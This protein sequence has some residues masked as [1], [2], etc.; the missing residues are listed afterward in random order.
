MSTLEILSIIA[1]LAGVACFAAVFTILYFSHARSTNAQIEAGKRDIE[2]IDEAIKARNPKVKKRKKIFSAIKTTLFVLFLAIVIPIFIFSL[3]TRIADG[4]PV[5]GKSFLVVASGSM[6]EL[7]EKNHY[8]AELEGLEKPNR[9]QQYDII[10][11]DK[12][13]SPADLKR[14]DVVAY[15][16]DRGYTIIH[17]I[18][19]I[20]GHG[21]DLK[22]T[23]CGDANETEDSYHATF[24]DVIG[25]YRGTRV[26]GVGIVIMFL[27]SYSGIITV[28]ALLY[29]LIMA[30]AVSRKI[31][32]CED[33][34]RKKLLEAIEGGE[35]AAKE[36]RAEF[37][38]TI[39]YRGYAYRFDEK[40][41]IDKTEIPEGQEPE[42]NTMVKVFESG[43]ESRSHAIFIETKKP[44]DEE[45][46]RPRGK[47]AAKDKPKEQEES[48]ARSALDEKE[49]LKEEG[50]KA[51]PAE[52]SV[53][54]EEANPHQSPVGDSFP[55]EEGE[56]LDLHQSPVGDSFPLGEGKPERPKRKLRIK[57]K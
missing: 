2:L 8:Y 35:D 32:K 26:K 10:I 22:L 27:Q 3:V 1:T 23:T 7:N 6:S 41:F 12:V 56:A 48:S 11:L 30:D 24:E 47:D 29:C 9:F 36:M 44:D 33:A 4:R 15:R 31:E 40:G 19:N 5:L 51:E 20:E 45:E 57:R 14:F 42:K 38:E 13:N 28:V 39:Y 52:T 17:R 53:E 43:E 37:K 16:N 50:G 54:V 25:V 46:G 21:A 49:A 55:L 34:R 18:V